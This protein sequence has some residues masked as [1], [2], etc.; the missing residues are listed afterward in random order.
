MKIHFNK[1]RCKGKNKI[2]AWKIK[3][4]RRATTY[5]KVVKVAKRIFLEIYHKPEQT[6]QQ[7]RQETRRKCLGG[8]FGSCSEWC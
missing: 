1:K 7:H 8:V 4:E 2:K 6:Q 5:L 3:E